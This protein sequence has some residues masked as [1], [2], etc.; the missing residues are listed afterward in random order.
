MRTLR[1]V[2]LLELVMGGIEG[3]G[4]EVVGHEGEKGKGGRERRT[5]LIVG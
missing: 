3:S 4:G 2:S 5:I 1:V